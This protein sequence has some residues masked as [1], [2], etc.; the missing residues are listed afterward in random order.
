MY[1]ASLQEKSCHKTY[2]CRLMCVTVEDRNNDLVSFLIS[3]YFIIFRKG[4]PEH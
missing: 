4:L 2:V 1:I 3:L